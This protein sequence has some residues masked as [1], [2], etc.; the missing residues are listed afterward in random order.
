MD[1]LTPLRQYAAGA[2]LDQPNL[3]PPVTTVR[4]WDGFFVGM[5][6]G[7][8]KNYMLHLGA[9][10]AAYQVAADEYG[11]THLTILDGGEN[12]PN[13]AI[14]YYTLPAV[15][16]G[17]GPISLAFF[18][19]DGNEIR[20]FEGK[21]GGVEL[22]EGERAISVKPGLNRF[23][24]DLRYPDAAKIAGD[25]TT[26]KART[27]PRA[28]P[29]LYQVE[30]SVGDQRWRSQFELIIDPRLD[31]SQADLDA[32]FELGLRIRDKVNEVHEAAARLRWVRVQISEWASRATAS[33]KVGHSL[34]DVVANAEAI[35]EKLT[36]IE[37]ELV[38][39]EARTASDR[40]RMKTRLNQ[41]LITLISVVAAADARPTRQTY[42]VFEHLSAQADEQ[43]AALEQVLSEDVTAFVA[44]LEERGA[45]LIVT[46]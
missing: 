11:E 46:T 40:L 22:A 32:Q 17:D 23:V 37:H 41:K 1:D 2:A 42:D 35:Q 4:H 21:P 30:L 27:G 43:L 20:R 24:W 34:D 13:G 28:A 12:P 9:A 10:Q 18:D 16:N 14:V 29:G 19:A 44:L 15:I 6:S 25:P 33:K 39:T 7:P 26:E 38:Q 45:P 36:A 31:V 8:G 5:W 3:F